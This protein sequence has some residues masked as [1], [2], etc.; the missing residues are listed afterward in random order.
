MAKEYVKGDTGILK[1]DGLPIVC[2]SNTSASL[3]AET[4]DRISYCTNG[5]VQTSV[6]RVSEE[7][8]IDGFI[9]GDEVEA[10][11]LGYLALRTAMLSKEPQS[12]ELEGRGRTGEFMAVITSLSDNFPTGE[13]ATFSATIVVQPSQ[14]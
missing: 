13:D 11:E 10:T 12:F 3:T 9:M 6:K 7:I 8:S 14:A 4:V 1:M 2:L 5:E